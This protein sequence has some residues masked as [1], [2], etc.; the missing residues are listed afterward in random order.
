MTSWIDEEI[1]IG[2]LSGVLIGLAGL[3]A[4]YLLAALWRDT[5]WRQRGAAFQAGVEALGLELMR[6]PLP[7]IGAIW[8]GWR[9]RIGAE[10][11]VEGWRVRLWL[12]GGLRG[13][14][15]ILLARGP[16][17]RRRQVAE[18]ERVDQLADWVRGVLAGEL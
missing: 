3:C 12:A 9:S 14:R 15:L 13:E 11:R 6:R 17:G 16:G 18:I 2:S 5:L 1:L 4:L 10:G 8:S 7:E